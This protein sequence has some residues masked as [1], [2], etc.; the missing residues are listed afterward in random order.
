[1]KN[2]EKPGKMPVLIA[3]FLL[4][5]LGPLFS[6][7][8][9]QQGEDA[10]M[11]NQPEKTVTLLTPLAEGGSSKK[12]TYLYLGIALQQLGRYSEAVSAFSR[13]VEKTLPP[14]DRL[15][16]NMGNNY[17]LLNQDTDAERAFGRAIQENSRLAS[18][19]LNRANT[20]MRMTKYRDA[21]ADYRVYL[22]QAPDSPQKA[23]IEDLINRLDGYLASEEQRKQQEAAARAA[24]EE[25]QR[26]LL[27]SVL[28]S[29]ENAESDTV[30]MRAESEDVESLDL[31]LD[32]ED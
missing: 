12:E 15:Y 3:G 16:F 11:N 31:E 5:A 18:A 19:Y 2:P 32:I 7:D 13:G 26:A 8:L 1:M 25:R 4:L 29:L 28:S 6:Q 21:A 17:F 27:A 24:E 10:F 23:A 30:N 14:Y 20:R 9:F 22:I